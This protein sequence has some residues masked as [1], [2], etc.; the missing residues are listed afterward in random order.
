MIAI[1]WLFLPNSAYSSEFT[2][3]QMFGGKGEIC[4]TDP[5]PTNRRV[6][7][8]AREFN[9]EREVHANVHRTCSIIGRWRDDSA[10]LDYLSA[11]G[12]FC[13]EF[14]KMPNPV[15]IQAS[16]D[17]VCA[18]GPPTP[19]ER[20]EDPA[21][22]EGVTNFD[23]IDDDLIVYPLIA[24]PPSAKAC[25]ARRGTLKGWVYRSY[26]I[27]ERRAER[28][29]ERCM[30]LIADSKNASLKANFLPHFLSADVE[31]CKAFETFFDGYNRDYDRYVEIQVLAR[32]KGDHACAITRRSW[33]NRD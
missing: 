2:V 1:G 21:S 6:W 17:H 3:V 15:V 25:L 7:T 14:E 5:G 33:E 9:I 24:P 4:G 20:R 28:R 30:L 23:A 12:D 29:E 16:P 19:K 22:G 27:V 31:V 11:R 13:R 26:R 32:P 8:T 18:I 10:E